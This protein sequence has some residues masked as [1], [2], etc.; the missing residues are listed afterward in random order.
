MNARN[1][2]ILRAILPKDVPEQDVEFFNAY[3]SLNKTMMPAA[4][5]LSYSRNQSLKWAI[6]HAVI[7]A[8]YVVWVVSSSLT[9]EKE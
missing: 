3:A 6:I 8:P 9:R 1:N 4:F 2:S 5:L 7:G